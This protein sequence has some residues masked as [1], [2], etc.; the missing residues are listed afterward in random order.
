MASHDVLVNLIRDVDK[1]LDA[2]SSAD[3]WDPVF[4]DDDRGQKWQELQLVASMVAVFLICIVKDNPNDALDLY[5]EE[6]LAFTRMHRR[7]TK[8]QNKTQWGFIG[9]VCIGLLEIVEADLP[10][11]SS[12]LTEKYGSTCIP[13]LQAAMP[14]Y[15]PR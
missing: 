7:P 14:Y 2:H 8:T 12:T 11:L 13:T 15:E 10:R 3:C 1:C 6:I 4:K 9:K 5:R